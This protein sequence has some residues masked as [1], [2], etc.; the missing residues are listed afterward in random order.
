MD[1]AK[2]MNEASV[3]ASTI[4]LKKGQSLFRE[5]EGAGAMYLVRQG[6]IRISKKKGEADIEID[7]IRSG[8]LVGELAFLDGNP[9]S[10]SAEAL[11]ETE[12]VEISGPAFQRVL[13]TI[14]E[15]LKILLKTL[16]TRLR[17]ASTKI[18]QLETSSSEYVFSEKDGKRVA[19]HVYLSAID[20]M[21]V[22]TAILLV[23][24][25]W[26]DPI[27]VTGREGVEVN[28][29]L[30]LRYA[31]QILQVPSSKVTSVIDA[32]SMAG[33]MKTDTSGT[34][35][36][37]DI[38]FLE[39]LIHYMNEENL[40]EPSK[41]HDISNR[42]FLT[43]SLVL[44]HLN[45]YP[46]DADGFALVNVAEILKKETP[47]G[48]RCP[49]RLDD[50]AELVK[51]GYASNVTAKSADEVLSS[52]LVEDFVAA[53]RFQRVIKSIEA[54]NEQKRKRKA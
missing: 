14:P 45:R 24:D 26:G 21:K 43:M 13:G 38:N 20:V 53:A 32:F 40:Q 50:F 18:R 7:S 52:I 5:G 27:E 33:F 23:A 1:P 22:G 36:L 46:K 16:V 29:S 11:C 37:F 8:Q 39:K 30:L 34:V 44:K 25:R 6:S 10:A 48:G 19:Q 3:S 17:S 4:R 2:A 9:R 51:L 54:L 49:V 31:N 15:W 41:R 47:E 12:L 28:A 42:G 35:A